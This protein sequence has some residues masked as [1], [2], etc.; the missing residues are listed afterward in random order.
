M[1]RRDSIKTLLVTSL[2]SG[3]VLEGCLPKEKE[4]IYEKVWKY[5][6]GRTPEEKKRDLELLNK[7]FFTKDEIQK[8]KTLANLILPP[9]PIGNIE[10]AEVIEF[11]E[12]IV[13]DVPSLKKTIRNGLYWI[14]DYCKNNF[15][16]TFIES[17]QNE[18]K[19][20][21]D[22]VAFPKNNKTKEEI[23]FSTFRDLVITGYF[24]SE[25]GIKDLGYKGNQPNI[26]DGVPEEILKEHGLSYD[27]SWASKFIDQSKRNDVAVWDDKGN[28]IS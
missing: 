11:I 3:L 27:K 7:T 4:I 16:K 17:N 2:A 22:L 23:F 18:Q 25:V 14:D 1:K 20:V 15:N 26:W 10:Q 13:K 21:L 12:F 8:I 5:Q 24:T 9:S 6:Y 28:L 19:R